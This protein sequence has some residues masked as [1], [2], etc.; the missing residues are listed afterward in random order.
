M[1]TFTRIKCT[2]HS[3]WLDKR[4]DGIGG[5]DA[6]AIL[7]LN[8]WKTSEQLWEEKVDL[9]DPDDS[10]S[11]LEA[12][13]YGTNAEAPLRSLF[14]LD[15]PEHKVYYR[16]NEILR[17]NK[18]PW[19]QASLDGELTDPDGRMGILEIKTTSILQSMQREKWRD[20][21][22]PN[23]YVQLLHYLLVTGYDFVILKA[24]LKSIWDGQI[25]ISTRHYTFERADVINDLK[26]LLAAEI[27]FWNFIKTKKRPPLR[28]PQI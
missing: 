18:L 12:V 3:D 22:P 10:I 8:P 16:K 23:Y 19:M 21:V 20:Q 13:K 7:G 24:Q 11:S 5:S 28:L 25:Q 14:K 27:R 26:M 17:N 2:S 1:S 4:K 9:A 15:H 6:S